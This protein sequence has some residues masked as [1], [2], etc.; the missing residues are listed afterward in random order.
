MP[1]APG[2][3]EMIEQL[4]ATPSVSAVDSDLDMGNADV[5]D[6]LAGW[7]E[8]EGF[9]V[10]RME[11]PGSPRNANLIARRGGG[12]GG[13][14][15]SGHTDT[16][17]WDEGAWS[18]DPFRITE[19]DGAIYGLGVA[20]MKS[21][22]ALAIEAARVFDDR[23]LQEPLIILAT[24]DEE[25]GMSGAQALLDART[26]RARRAVIGEPTSLRPIRMHKGCGMERLELTGR[27]G[28]SSDPALGVNALDGMH[29]AIGALMAVR[30]ELASRR[31]EELVPPYSTLNLGRIE[32]G[33]NP[34]R[35]CGRCTL[36]YDLRLIPGLPVDEVRE[37]IEARVRE[38]LSGRDIEVRHEPLMTALP[39]F[40]TPADAAL[41]RLVEEL[42]G[43]DAG[44]VSFGTEAPF[45]S[46]LG[47][48]TVVLGPGDIAVAH[49]PDERLAL[50]DLDPTVKLLRELIA[51]TCI[52]ETRSTS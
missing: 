46:A 33:D 49:Q 52:R 37:A 30:E 50:E 19:R 36:D 32:G 15:L 14:V 23:Q 13:L 5:S 28:H 1:G 4:V 9:E 48:E 25:S 38:A 26:L 42:T 34:N 29:A 22:L 35:I 43:R 40:E 16:V 45:L 2:T 21:F 39:S 51:R 44:A 47:I 12:E 8:D 18:S 7:L 6:L 24:A 41:V 3:R 17:P 11:L 27:A 20:D 10:E 31:R